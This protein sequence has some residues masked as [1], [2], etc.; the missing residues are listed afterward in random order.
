M[1]RRI[2]FLSVGEEFGADA[3]SERTHGKAIFGHRERCE[4][5][6]VQFPMGGTT[7][8]IG[9]TSGADGPSVPGY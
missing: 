3:L 1:P 5:A 9:K 2:D 7:T 8:N 4:S 6:T